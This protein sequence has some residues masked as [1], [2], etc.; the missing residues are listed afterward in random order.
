MNRY[1]LKRRRRKTKGPSSIASVARAA[2]RLMSNQIPNKQNNKQ[3]KSSFKK[4]VT[5][6]I[7]H[8][9]SQYALF[10][11]IQ[12][13]NSGFV[14]SRPQTRK[15]D[16]NRSQ[17]RRMPP[18]SP[19]AVW[20]CMMWDPHPVWTLQIFTKTLRTPPFLVLPQNLRLS[21]E[22]YEMCSPHYHFS[23]RSKSFEKF[24]QHQT[25]KYDVRDQTRFSFWGA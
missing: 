14:P 7:F 23:K 21:N 9:L 24:K 15:I 17:C 11:W 16:A 2:P 22:W 4:H 1:T 20:W 13:P 10:H 19:N 12:G 25:T 3:H 6:S 8:P 5:W 18:K